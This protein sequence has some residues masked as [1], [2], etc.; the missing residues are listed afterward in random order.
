MGIY[1][2]TAQLQAVQG[3]AESFSLEEMDRAIQD[4]DGVI[5]SWL[6]CR[7]S[8]PLTVIP[9]RLQQVA[10]DIARYRLYREESPQETR[11]RYEDGVAFLRDFSD[12][13]V[14]LGVTEEEKPAKTGSR[15]VVVARGRVFG[16]DLLDKMA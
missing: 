15:V 6:G 11:L 5:N 9:G 2:T 12:G 10:L 3:D 4:A 13:R 16:R 14:T 8:L 1:C 7:V